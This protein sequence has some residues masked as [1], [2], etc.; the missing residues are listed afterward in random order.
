MKLFVESAAVLAPGLMG[1]SDSRAVLA[2]DQEY[3]PAPFVSPAAELL[4]AVERRRTGS[5]VKLALAAGQQALSNAGRSAD[6]VATVFVSSGNDGDVINDICMTLAGSDRQVSPT[7]FHNSVHNAPSGYWGIAAHSHHPSTSL[8]AFDWSFA[9]GLLEAATQLQV[10]S[11]EVLLIAYDIPYPMPF[12]GIRRIEQPFG[13]ALLM[14]RHCTDRSIA[15]LAIELDQAPKPPSVM[16]DGR[17]ETLRLGNPCARALPLLAALARAQPA[18]VTLQRN[19]GQTIAI[20][21]QPNIRT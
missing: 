13:T 9:I 2:G 17:L 16:V 3:Q 19:A 1:W 12:A 4:P 7:R 11:T 14:T 18:T 21:T 6:S 10:E 15:G 5:T 8:C 20:F